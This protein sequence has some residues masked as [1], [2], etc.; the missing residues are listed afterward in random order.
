MILNV[1][2]KYQGERHLFVD[3][4]VNPHNVLRGGL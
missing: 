1:L 2:A 3:E 4:E